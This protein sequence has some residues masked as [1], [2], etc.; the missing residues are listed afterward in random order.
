MFYLAQTDTTAGFLSKNQ[1]EINRAKNRA[2]RTPCIL[3]MARFSE[4]LRLVRVPK[5]HKNLVRKARKTSFVYETSGFCVDLNG[6]NAA[7]IHKNPTQKNVV[8]IHKNAAAKSGEK[9]AACVNFKGS[10]ACRVVKECAHSEFLAKN[11]A[12]FS[13]SA[14]LHGEKFD[15]QKA[16]QITL[17]NGGKIIDERLFAGKPSAL[18][19]LFRVKKRK[20]R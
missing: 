12:F 7:K 15:F 10:L 19:R 6:E 20:I 13:S 18:I 16:R 2:L 5:A 3:T 14:N 1:A 4:L 11:G 17:A 8:K 9:G